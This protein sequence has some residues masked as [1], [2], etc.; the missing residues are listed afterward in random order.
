MPKTNTR[1]MWPP[2]PWDTEESNYRCGKNGESRTG[3]YFLFPSTHCVCAWGK[4]QLKRPHGKGKHKELCCW[5]VPAVVSPGY[6][7]NVSKGKQGE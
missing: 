6:C 1:W 7:F 4:S 2:Y 5:V 3:S